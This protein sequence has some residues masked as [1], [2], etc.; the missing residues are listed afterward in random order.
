MSRMRRREFIGNSSIAAAGVALSALHTESAERRIGRRSRGSGTATNK[1]GMNLL[2]WTGNP[3]PEQYELLEMLGKIGFDGVEFPM[4]DTSGR[5]WSDLGKKCDELGLERTVST[6]LPKDSI[7]VSDDPQLRQNALEFLKGTVDRSHELGAKVICGPLCAPVGYLVG[8]GRTEEEFNRCV[9]VIRAASEYA[10]QAE[11]MFTN[12]PLNRFE[13]YVINSQEDGAKL[14]DAV[15]MP[16]FKLHYD[17]F[18]AN[19]EEKDPGAVIKKVGNV[20]GHVHISEN[21]RSTPGKGQV[22]WRET[23]AALKDVNY[24]GWLVIEAFGRALPEI[25]AAT[26]IWRQMYES[27]EQLAGDGYAFV[28]RSWTA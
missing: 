25:A 13:T 6:A 15:N 19:I 22:H 7:P 23:F 18:H 16:S 11:I 12:E 1:I 24:Q 10:Q 9:E 21:D 2:L 20:I 28:K 3:G 17:T 26:C 4:F 8:R 5:Q 27:E 14:V